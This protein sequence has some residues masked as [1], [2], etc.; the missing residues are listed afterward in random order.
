MK[1][2]FW[3]FALFVLTL[4][5]ILCNAFYI[6]RVSDRLLEKLESL[7]D[8]TNENCIAAAEELYQDWMKQSKLAE[9]SVSYPILDRVTE[10]AA[11]LVTCAKC[12]DHYGYRSAIALL[13][14]A[15][16]DMRRLEPLP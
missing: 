1:S 16:E 5:V 6:N 10:Q 12:K 9:M 3:S 4:I 15:V 14:D 7:P 11:L 8:I 2:F 13:T